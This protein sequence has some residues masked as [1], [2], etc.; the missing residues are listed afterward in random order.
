VIGT[1]GAELHPSFDT[2]RV[3]A[4]F[5]KGEW[6]AAYSGFEGTTSDGTSLVDWLH[7]RSVDTV[8]IVGIATDH[9]VRATALDAAKAGFDTTVILDYT[10]GVSAETVESALN[11]MRSAGVNLVGSVHSP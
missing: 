10:A 4:I 1:P 7:A 11:E 8:D 9:C 3:E 6:Q 5:D 2:Q